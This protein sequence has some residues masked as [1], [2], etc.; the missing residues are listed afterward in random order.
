VRKIL[1]SLFLLTCF[2]LLWPYIA[3]F[4]LYICLQ[5]GDAAGV[6]ERV[7][8]FTIK[9]YLRVDLDNF[10]NFKLKESLEQKKIQMNFDSLTLSKQISDKIATPTG[11]IYLFNKP[12][13]F[14][15]QISQI[16]SNTLSPENI[17]PPVP[18]KKAFRPEGPNFPDMF[19]RI[20][21]AFFIKTDKFRLSFN[22]GDLSFI[23]E[24]RLQGFFWKLNRLKVPI[25]TN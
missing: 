4:S 21:Y 19:D 17:K 1:F 23:L 8:W 16:F 25:K 6:E 20:K 14:F 13:E 5:T 15:E 11:L 10:A 9:K 22:K 24:W 3:V 12:N 18:K 2:Y 7:D